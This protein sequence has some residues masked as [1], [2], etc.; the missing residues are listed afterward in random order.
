GL[1]RGTN[2][3]HPS[4]LGEERSQQALL[5]ELPRFLPANL[6]GQCQPIE[7]AA[8]LAVCEMERCRKWLLC[9]VERSVALR[10]VKGRAVEVAVDRFRRIGASADFANDRHAR[11]P[12]IHPMTLRLRA[13]TPHAV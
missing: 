7:V 3:V 13:P 9:Q 12:V 11:G 1:R 4:E 5:Q 6:A 2:Q 8:D 10:S